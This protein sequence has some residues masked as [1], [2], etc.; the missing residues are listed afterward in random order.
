MQYVYHVFDINPYIQKLYDIKGMEKE[1]NAET[2]FHLSY[3]DFI[4][5]FLTDMLQYWAVVW[6]CALLHIH[7]YIYSKWHYGVHAAATTSNNMHTADSTA[8]VTDCTI[9][10]LK[11]SVNSIF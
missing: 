10:T 5:M 11:R 2:G 9:L 7:L 4:H 3:V 8:Q 1:K 6:V